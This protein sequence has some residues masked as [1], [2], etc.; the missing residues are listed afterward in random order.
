MT[1]QSTWSGNARDVILALRT[2]VLAV[3]LAFGVFMAGQ[4]ALDARQT[5]ETACSY[6]DCFEGAG[7]CQGDCGIWTDWQEFHNRP[8][9]FSCGIGECVFTTKA[10]PGNPCTVCDQ[11]FT[12]QCLGC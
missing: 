8:P 4:S 9:C 3:G 6:I 10:Q 11:I 7:A 2:V 12:Q 5:C 1:R